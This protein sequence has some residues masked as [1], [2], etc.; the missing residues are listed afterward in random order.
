MKKQHFDAQ[1]S[2]PLLC[3]EAREAGNRK[4][5]VVG[6]L[7]AISNLNFRREKLSILTLSLCGNNSFY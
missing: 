2:T 1:L 6:L 5:L 7:H 3:L 4:G